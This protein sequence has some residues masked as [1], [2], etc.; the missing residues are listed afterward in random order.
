MWS[1]WLRFLVGT[2]LALSKSSEAKS[3]QGS[4][5]M[6]EADMKK[7]RKPENC[8]YYPLCEPLKT[9]VGQLSLE[10]LDTYTD[11]LTKEAESVCSLCD[12]FQRKEMLGKAY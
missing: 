4:G 6:S 3:S 10:L 12:D 7:R 2:S 9:L 1:F 11:L 5:M 8:M